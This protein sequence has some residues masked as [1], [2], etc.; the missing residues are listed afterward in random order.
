MLLL[1]LQAD[2]LSLIGSILLELRLN[3]IVIGWY[4]YLIGS[5]TTLVAHYYKPVKQSY[6]SPCIVVL[7]VT[8]VI[9]SIVVSALL[10]ENSESQNHIGYAIGWI[11]ASVYFIGRLPQ[12]WQNYKARSTDGLSLT[13]Y[14]L[15]M[16]GNAAFIG[17]VLFFS[18][19]PNYIHRNLP[20]LVM[21]VGIIALDIVVVYQWLIYRKRKS[22]PAPGV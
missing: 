16:A 21:T 5:V 14:T 10:Q 13:M 17:S 22:D 11:A 7:L 18:I 9:V 20:W 15:A 12:M 3:L 6:E 2:A 19:E 4:H 8:N 1:W